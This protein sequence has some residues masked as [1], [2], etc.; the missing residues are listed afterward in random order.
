MKKYFI[1][2]LN[3]IFTC[4]LFSEE[5]SFEP[6]IVNGENTNFLFIKPT[7]S[8][9][10]YSLGTL[11][12]I[13]KNNEKNMNLYA[14]ITKEDR[15]PI[16]LLRIYFTVDKEYIDIDRLTFKKKGIMPITLNLEEAL[17]R[18]NY[19]DLTIYSKTQKALEKI[20]TYLSKKEIVEVEILSSGGFRFTYTMPYQDILN[21]Y[22]TAIFYKEN[23][24]II[25]PNH[26]IKKEDIPYGP[27]ILKEGKPILQELPP[28]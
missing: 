18:G 9:H 8:L 2:L 24:R 15:Y 1:F 27:L 5:D 12:Q 14:I 25:P 28:F 26:L 13:K 3:L 6:F 23:F 20:G 4:F 10:I 22:E 16:D 11:E 7:S 19:V 17:I 21:L